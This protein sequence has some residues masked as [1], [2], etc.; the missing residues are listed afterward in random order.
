MKDIGYPAS[1]DETVYELMGSSREEVHWT[2]GQ[3]VCVCECV[4]VCVCVC[5]RVC[6]RMHG[7]EGRDATIKMHI[8]P[9]KIY[10]NILIFHF[11]FNGR[12]ERSGN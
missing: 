9:S 2:A 6:L 4:C 11:Y 7:T 1:E 3:C 5:A 10:R 12:E 8:Y